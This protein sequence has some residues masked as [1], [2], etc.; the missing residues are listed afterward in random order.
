MRFGMCTEG[1]GEKVESFQETGYDYVELTVGEI[2]PEE[3]EEKFVGVKEKIKKFSLQP[4]V[5]N[6][7]IPGE[8][9]VVGDKIDSPRLKNYLEVSIRRIA[10]LSGKIIVFGSGGARK[11]PEGFPFEK[12]YQQL[13]D[14]LD[15]AADIAKNEGI[16]IVIEPLFKPA[17]NII[18]SVK[19]G[20]QLTK[21]V[22]RKEVRLLA[23]L[24][25][26]EE[27]DE[28]FTNLL[29]TKDYLVH[30]HIPV[31]VTE[32]VRPPSIEGINLKKQSYNHR[33]FFHHLKEIN[34]QGRISVED[35]GGGLEDIEKEASQLLPRLKKMWEEA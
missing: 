5:F 7:F 17:T 23:D 13:I 26:M 22:D 14:F 34:Y 16:V 25:H 12:A 9:K 15:L 28:P 11:V 10:E 2:L 29:A 24:F 3:S 35:N 20:L 30:I 6:C 27:E 31:P 1:L 18:N 33:D 21:D 19:E 32:G 8:I 4:E